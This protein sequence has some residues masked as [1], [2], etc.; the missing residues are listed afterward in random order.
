MGRREAVLHERGGAAP[1]TSTR[2]GFRKVIGSFYFLPMNETLSNLTIDKQKHIDFLD[3]FCGVISCAARSFHSAISG[4]LSNLGTSNSFSVG[5]F[6]ERLS[7]ARQVLARTWQDRSSRLQPKSQGTDILGAIM[8]AAEIFQAHG[9][10]RKLLVIYS[11]MRH[12]GRDLDLETRN[13]ISVDAALKNV[14]KGE[15]VPDLKE[16][17]V[18]ALGVVLPGKKCGNGKECVSSGSH[19]L[20][21]LEQ[22]YAVIQFCGM[23]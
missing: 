11:D 17:Q 4:D 13:D 12:F 21:N 3:V 9:A 23:S 15:L 14:Q 6:G 7:S 5:Y 20:R 22:S 2:A 16:V 8:V 19:T 18:Y 10:R 1:L